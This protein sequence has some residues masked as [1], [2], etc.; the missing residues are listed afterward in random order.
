MR[1]HKLNV[2]IPN[3]HQL[4]IAVRLPE[5]FPPGPA[6]VIVQA[7]PSTERTLD[8]S[9]K[10]ALALVDELRSLQRTEEEENLLDEFADFQREHPF[11]LTSLTE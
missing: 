11:R 6:E 5:D 1:V 2:T 7:D 4:E 3:D 8:G 10:A 9:R